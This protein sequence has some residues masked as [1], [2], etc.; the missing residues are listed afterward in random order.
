VKL[1]QNMIA[2]TRAIA[3]PFPHQTPF[4]AGSQMNL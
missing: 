2:E 4:I 3:R 1:S